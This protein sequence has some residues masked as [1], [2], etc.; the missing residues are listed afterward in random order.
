[1]ARTGHAVQA[2]TPLGCGKVPASLAPVELLEQVQLAIHALFTP[3]A[4]S[5]RAR[6]VVQPAHAVP[7]RQLMHCTKKVRVQL[8][9]RKDGALCAQ[10]LLQLGLARPDCHGTLCMQVSLL[11]AAEVRS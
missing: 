3:P 7:C 10:I 9:L 4:A 6:R 5:R 1:M 11:R 8:P 2:G